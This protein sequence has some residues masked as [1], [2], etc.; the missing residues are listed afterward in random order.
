MSFE[1]IRDVPLWIIAFLISAA[2]H[3]FA[4]AW[5]AYKLGDDTAARAGRLTINP[6]PH[7]DPIGLIFLTLMS[8]SGFGIGWAKPVPVN[9]YNFRNPRRDNMLVSLSGP[10]SN[11][12]QAAFFVIF[13]KLFP[14]LFQADNPIGHLLSIFLE[15]N[16][17]LAAFNLIPIAPLDGSH[18]VEGLLPEKLA[19]G[20]RKTYPYGFLILIVL[21]FTGLLWLILRPIITF[22]SIVIGLGS[23]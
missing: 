16:I 21:M 14:S 1:N 8:L 5:T 13:F 19:D 23:F 3:E 15:L 17:L 12:I 11:I 7:I 9:P 20:W 4:H 22:I 2:F 10:V 18:I 6:I